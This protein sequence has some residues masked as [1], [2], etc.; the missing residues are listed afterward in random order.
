MSIIQTQSD[1]VTG[2]PL[3]LIIKITSSN[4][5]PCKLLTDLRRNC[6]GSSRHVSS[7]SS[8]PT[9]ELGLPPSFT[10]TT[11]AAPRNSQREGDQCN[12]RNVKP[13]QPLQKFLQ[14]IFIVAGT[15]RRREGRASMR[16]R[17]AEM[18]ALLEG[19]RKWRQLSVFHPQVM[20][21]EGLHNFTKK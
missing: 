3:F 19:C 17:D 14:N 10:G 15:R 9:W 18:W 20:T 16:E 4:V 5:S 2:S 13:Q 21:H 11:W 8:S 6:Q 12:R 1:L 7:V